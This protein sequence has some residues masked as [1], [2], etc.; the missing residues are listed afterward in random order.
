MDIE[1]HR[2]IKLVLYIL[3]KQNRF[4]FGSFSD[5]FFPH[6]HFRQTKL[7]RTHTHTTKLFYWEF[8]AFTLPIIIFKRF[9]LVLQQQNTS[10]T[11]FVVSHNLFTVFVLLLL[12]DPILFLFSYFVFSAFFLRAFIQFSYFSYCVPQYLEYF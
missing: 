11:N 1:Q 12:L 9:F 6:W 5:N 4:F 3:N 7:S 8:Y 2:V 10:P